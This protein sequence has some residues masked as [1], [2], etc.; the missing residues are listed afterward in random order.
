MITL[1]FTKKQGFTFSLENTVLEKP[2]NGDKIDLSAFLVLRH[3]SKLANLP[4][5][6]TVETLI[7]LLKKLAN[8]L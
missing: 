2:Q 7:N 5:I 8:L 3:K 1:I 4:N 6:T